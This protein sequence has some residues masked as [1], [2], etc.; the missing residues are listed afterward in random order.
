LKRIL[1]EVRQAMRAEVSSSAAVLRL[2]RLLC[3]IDNRL[4]CA[5]SDVANCIRFV[6]RSS[7]R[8]GPAAVGIAV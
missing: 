1:E 5:A 8:N 7:E 6:G 3:R 4:E 2:L